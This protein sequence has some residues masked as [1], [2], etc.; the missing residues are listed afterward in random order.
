MAIRIF[1]KQVASTPDLGLE[2]LPLPALL[3]GALLLRK[4]QVTA[5]MLKELLTTQVLTF[6]PST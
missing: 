4:D 5:K 1:L 6:L 3:T 2:N